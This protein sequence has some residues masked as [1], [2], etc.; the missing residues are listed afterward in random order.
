MAWL[1]R[2]MA[3]LARHGA[4]P[5]IPVSYRSIE[6]RALVSLFACRHSRSRTNDALAPFLPWWIVGLG[7]GVGLWVF[8]LYVMAHLIAGLPAFLGF[9]QLTWASLVGHM[10]FG[11]IAAAVVRWRESRETV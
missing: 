2:Q 10:L 4:N 7:F 9:I 8:A 3:P 6:Q 5:A 1:A 11:L